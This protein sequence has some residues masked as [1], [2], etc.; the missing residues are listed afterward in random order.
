[1]PTPVWPVSLPAHPLIDGYENR[2]AK[3]TI[4]TSME[5]GPDKLRRRG[6]AGVE[7]LTLRF[8]LT[9][10]Q[11]ATFREFYYD[12]LSSGTLA[13]EFTHPDTESTE[14]MRFVSEPVV[15]PARSP[16]R[17]VVSFELEVLP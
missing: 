16:L 8:H 14:N 9:L 3:N 11:L 6:T 12:T 13:F 7:P 4:R 10:A 15:T 5:S 2:F 1:M 17:R